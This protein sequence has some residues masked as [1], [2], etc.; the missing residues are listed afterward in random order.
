MKKTSWIYMHRE[1]NVFIAS[2]LPLSCPPPPLILFQILRTRIPNPILIDCKQT[3]ALRQTGAV[4]NLTDPRLPPSL[5]QAQPRR[6]RVRDDIPTDRFLRIWVEH[7]TRA[8]VDLC[9]DL[10]GND[11]RDAEFVREAL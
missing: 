8:T 11:D 1:G 2:L 7:G 4:I 5:L 6:A 10:I 3:I 9:D